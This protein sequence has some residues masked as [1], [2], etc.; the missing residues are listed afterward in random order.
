[1]RPAKVRTS[2]ITLMMVQLAASGRGVCGLPGWAAQEYVQRGWVK[3]LSLGP[4]GVWRTLYAAVRKEDAGTAYVKDFI[5]TARR[6][7]EATLEG[8]RRVRDGR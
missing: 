3:T 5:M 8:I 6:T 2:E 7:S 4:Q 1:M